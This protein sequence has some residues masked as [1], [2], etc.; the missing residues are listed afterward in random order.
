MRNSVIF[1]PFCRL[2][3][4]GTSISVIPE[5]VDP[6]EVSVYEFTVESVTQVSLSE[7]IRL[8]DSVAEQGNLS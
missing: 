7:I 5:G 3:M 6:R 4:G 1:L 8:V 2:E